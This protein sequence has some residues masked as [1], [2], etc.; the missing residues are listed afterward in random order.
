MIHQLTKMEAKVSA[1]PHQSGRKK[2]PRLSTVNSSQNDFFCES[3]SKSSPG[4]SG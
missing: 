4:N 1:T 2:A 3:K